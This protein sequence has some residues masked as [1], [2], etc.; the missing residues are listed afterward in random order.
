MDR[1]MAQAVPDPDS[2]W[3]AE[4]WVAAAEAALAEVGAAGVA[5]PEGVVRVVAACGN[6]AA[7]PGVEV[8]ELGAEAAPAEVDLEVEPGPVAVVLVA[9][10]ELAVVV[11]D[12]EVE[13]A[14][15]MEVDL[16]PA[17]DPERA[18]EAREAEAK[19]IHQGN[20]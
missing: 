1:G 15:D 13:V 18:P 19:R 6:P 17:A 4:E 3:A 14:E 11:A 16:D 12:S 5:A 10:V 2:A 7:G 20:G 8:E 9:P